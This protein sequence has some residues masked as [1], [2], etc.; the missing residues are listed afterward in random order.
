M[1]TPM[2]PA[3]RADA[4]RAI[5]AGRR[6][7][8]LIIDQPADLIGHSAAASGLFARRFAACIGRFIAGSIRTDADESGVRNALGPA[9]QP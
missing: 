3:E 7:R 2:T 5:L 9:S 8:D 4:S 6:A 1:A